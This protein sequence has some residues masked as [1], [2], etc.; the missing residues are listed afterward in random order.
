MTVL[1]EKSHDGAPD[2]P[3]EFDTVIVGAG[4]GGLRMLHEMRELGLSAVAIESGSDVGGTWYWN[5][6]PGARTD[7]ESW[8]YAFPIP[9]FRKNGTGPNGTRPSRKPSGT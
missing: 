5:R 7:S 9:K 4:F 6:Y 8:M 2:S 1:N 3:T